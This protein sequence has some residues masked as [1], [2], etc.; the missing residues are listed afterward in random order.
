ITAALSVL[1]F[2]LSTPTPYTTLF[3]S[4]RS[5]RQSLNVHGLFAHKMDELLEAPGLAGGIVAEQGL[6]APFLDVF[7]SAFGFVDSGQ[8]PARS[9]EHTSELQSRFDIACRLLPETK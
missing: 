3:R 8:L 9:E 7:A 6:D 4:Q 5:L 1:P 2:P